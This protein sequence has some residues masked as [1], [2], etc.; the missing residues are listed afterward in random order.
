MVQIPIGTRVALPSN[1]SIEFKLKDGSR[2]STVALRALQPNPQEGK[3]DIQVSVNGKPVSTLTEHRKWRIGFF[4]QGEMED[5]R[6]H[7]FDL[8]PFLKETKNRYQRNDPIVDIMIFPNGVTV[9]GQQVPLRD[10]T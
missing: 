7:T 1:H 5:T 2:T 9:A 8:T 3:W 6:Y 4:D 10:D